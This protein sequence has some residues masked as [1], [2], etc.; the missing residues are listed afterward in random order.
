MVSMENS[1]LC[2]LF[3]ICKLI[4]KL[5]AIWTWALFPRCLTLYMVIFHTHTSPIWNT[6]GPKHHELEIPYYQ[7]ISNACCVSASK[8]N[9]PTLLI[10]HSKPS[11]LVY[12]QL[13]ADYCVD[14]KIPLHVMLVGALIQLGGPLVSHVYH[15]MLPCCL[16]LR[17]A[18]LHTYCVVLTA[19]LPHPGTLTCKTCSHC[20]FSN[21]VGCHSVTSCWPKAA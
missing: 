2:K 1:P 17:E 5:Y 20:V 19:K 4:C 6:S 21:V 10:N 13:C 3:K 18:F 12:R 11:S 9:H 8:T 15:A 16:G 7:W 14:L